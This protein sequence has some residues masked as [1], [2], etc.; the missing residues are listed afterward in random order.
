[1]GETGFLRQAIQEPIFPVA[2]TGFEGG[3]DGRGCGFRHYFFG[4]IGPT[5]PL[6]M[7]FPRATAQDLSITSVP[8]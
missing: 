8:Q 5:R 7:S 6:L 3:G 4:Q 2:N 1:M